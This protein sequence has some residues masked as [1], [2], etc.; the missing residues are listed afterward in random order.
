MPEKD[1]CTGPLDRREQLKQETRERIVKAATEIL[2]AEGVAGFSMR[3]VADE[4][5][6]TATAIYV[7]FADKEA[8]LEE[9]VEREFMA[10][11]KAFERIGRVCDPIERL[12]KMGKA[13]VEFALEFPDHYRFMFLTSTLKALPKA[14]IVERGNPAQDCYAFL[15][16][17][18]HDALAAGRFRPEFK[19]VDEL[20]Q[21]FFAAMHGLVALHIVKGDDPWVEWRPVK[22]TARRMV[23]ALVRG[24]T[25]G[26]EELTG[27]GD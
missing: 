5:G 1:P 21:I 27:G 4:A 7:H 6:Y 10:F 3:K 15:K 22:T 19:D 16:A 12:A 18:L 11:R 8:L 17:T 14:G 25:R 9:V 2:L 23:E 26:G 13:Y 24:M 20:A